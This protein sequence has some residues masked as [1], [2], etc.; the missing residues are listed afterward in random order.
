MI[1]AAPPRLSRPAFFLVFA[2]SITTA[3]GNT[4]LQ[5]I[6]PAIGRQI[7]M[8]DRLV[9]SIFSLSA[10]LWGISSPYWARKSDTTGR[11]PVMM[12][13]MA[14][15]GLS[16]TLCPLVVSAGL[17]HLLPVLV[18]FVLFLMSRAIFGVLGSAANPASQAYVAER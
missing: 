17:H 3:F 18:V 13:G 9:V 8:D 14:G 4:G 10:L 11:K 15:F 5:S 7:G 1:D 6:L 12:L 2:L 16:M